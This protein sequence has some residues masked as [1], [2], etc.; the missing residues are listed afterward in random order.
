M[1][2]F[3]SV[4]IA[5]FHVIS[6]PFDGG[7]NIR[8]SKGA[9]SLIENQLKQ[10]GAAFTSET[11]ETGNIRTVHGDV[12]LKTLQSMDKN[13]KTVMLGGDHSLSIGS[14]SALH[15]FY[16][17]SR[18]NLGIVW[19]DAHADFNT[20]ETSPSGNV[21]GMPV[22]VLCGD[23]IP[24]LQFGSNLAYSQ[25]GY[26]GI[27]DVDSME[28]H[29][30]TS[31]NMREIYDVDDFWQWQNKFDALHVSFD[32]DCLDPSIAPGVKHTSK[33]RQVTGTMSFYV[34]INQENQEKFE[35]GRCRIQ[36]FE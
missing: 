11:V 20:V 33:R 10:D 25:I 5:Y 8:G 16:C 6:V 14:I 36:S 27:R 2:L 31:K 30:M 35:H 34:R 15:D 21:H 12:Y 24:S 32:V 26:Y 3:F 1:L 9:P 7:A 4:S 22:A 29:R 28:L 18:K 17:R 23:T 19:F 13:Q